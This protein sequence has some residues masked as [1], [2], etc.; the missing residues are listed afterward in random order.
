LCDVLQVAAEQALAHFS[1]QVT[2]LRFPRVCPAMGSSSR[3][4]V[5]VIVVSSFDS[6]AWADLEGISGSGR[7]GHPAA[8]RL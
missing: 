4:E 5:S 8:D 3:R 6:Q 7:A 1:A 2:G